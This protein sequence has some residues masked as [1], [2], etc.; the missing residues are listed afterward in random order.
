MVPEVRIGRLVA[1]EPTPPRPRTRADCIDGPR[2]CPWVACRHHLNLEV[3]PTGG[4]RQ[5]EAA[6]WTSEANPSCSLDL[7]DAHGTLTLE[8]VA[9]ILGLTR[10]RVRQVEM[11]AFARVRRKNPELAES[12]AEFERISNAQELDPT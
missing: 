8:Q 10:E 5:L 12:I 3:N 6:P 7:V 11:K 1:P 4:L 9:S 2:P